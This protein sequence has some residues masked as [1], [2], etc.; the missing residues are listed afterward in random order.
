MHLNKVTTP[1]SLDLYTSALRIASVLKQL[2]C[3][4][5]TQLGTQSSQINY[6]HSSMFDPPECLILHPKLYPFLKPDV[7]GFS[8]DIFKELLNHT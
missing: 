6:P 5:Q 2:S 7:P 3:E 4:G 8:K 1:H